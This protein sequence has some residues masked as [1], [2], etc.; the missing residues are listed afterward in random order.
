MKGRE[1]IAVAALLISMPGLTYSAPPVQEEPRGSE[2]SGQPAPIDRDSVLEDARNNPGQTFD[3]GGG[4]SVSTA[5]H[6]VGV[7]TD[8][9]FNDFLK[10]VNKAFTE[11]V[12]SFFE[13]ADDLH[14]ALNNTT[15]AFDPASREVMSKVGQVIGVVVGASGGV[16]AVMTTT[17]QVAGIASNDAQAKMNSF[18]LGFRLQGKDIVTIEPLGGASQRAASG[19][20]V[21]Q[22]GKPFTSVLRRVNGR[23]GIPLSPVDPPKLPSE[24]V[25]ERLPAYSELPIDHEE[26][27]SDEGDDG[28]L[29]DEL[30]V[31]GSGFDPTPYDEALKMVITPSRGEEVVTLVRGTTKLAVEKMVGNGS[32][33]GEPVD[34]SVEPPSKAQVGEQVRKG[35]VLPEFSTDVTVG[36]RF[37]RGHYL[38]V[39]GIKAK[40]LRPA[41][42]TEQGFATQKSAPIK[43]LKVYDRTFGKPE[44][45]GPNAS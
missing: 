40:Y 8:Y 16:G 1:A 4:V 33:G 20:V 45:S 5:P 43:V 6:T 18:P 32:A 34:I 23:I 19:D 9:T 25:A 17:G 24:F 29:P 10:I 11:P 2:S 39:V 26:Y 28:P 12:T 27:M 7:K 13:S 22:G 15:P 42:V 36:D 35:G 41:S 37:S 14:A 44:V 3:L 30:T 31:S 21:S 38:V